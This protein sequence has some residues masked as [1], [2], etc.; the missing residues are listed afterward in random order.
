MAID[1][2]TLL[3]T[4]LAERAK[5]LAYIRTLVRRRETAEDVF[6]DVCV[7][8]LEKRD[9]IVDPNHLTAWLRTGSRPAATAANGLR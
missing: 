8:A 2:D 6:Q 7:L 9:Q 5:V 4:L 1:H 3:R